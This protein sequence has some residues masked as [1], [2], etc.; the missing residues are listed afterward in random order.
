MGDVAGAAADLDGAQ[1]AIDMLGLARGAFTAVEPS[2]RATVAL[3]QGDPEDA[4]RIYERLIEG[5][6]PG[7]AIN[8]YG[9]SRELARILL[10]SGR[11]DEA[12]ATLE[13]LA[14]SGVAED[15]WTYETLSARLD[16]VRG[17]TGI[18]LE[19]SEAAAHGAAGTGLGL[20]KANVSLDRAHVLLAA[21][22]REE[23]RHA[24]VDARDQ[25]A[26]KQS[27]IGLRRAGE[28]LGRIDAAGT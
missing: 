1:S 19:R 13:R 12:A 28:L 17:Q 26:H 9:I 14:G 7:D 3:L 16:A 27:A 11:A 4:V 18:A 10:D 25:Y 6:R 8:R 23:A 21:D 20:L 24:A 5:L 2:A 15:R 22:R